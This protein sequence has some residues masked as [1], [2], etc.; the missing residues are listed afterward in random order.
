MFF[1]KKTTPVLELFI[2][3]LFM[4]GCKAGIQTDDLVS[5]F[6]GIQTGEALSPTTIRLSWEKRDGMEYTIYESSSS[7]PLDKTIF[8]S[9][10]VENLTPNTE[11][12]FKVVGT[13]GGEQFGTNRELRV[14]T[15]SRFSGVADL[16]A[17]TETSLEATWNYDQNPMAYQV[18]VG[19]D[20]PP[21][22][23]STN[24]WTA[25]TAT[26]QARTYTISNILPSK[27]YYVRVHAQYTSEEIEQAPR[28]AS[29]L[30]G[31]S[32]KSPNLFLAPISIG[33]LPFIEVDPVPDDTHVRSGFRSQAFWN[34]NAVSD[35]LSG[36]GILIF[37]SNAGLPIGLVEN[38][39]IRVEYGSG[40]SKEVKTIS[41]LKT[42]IKGISPHLEKP[43]V[44]SL[45]QG[46]AYFGKALAR[47]DFNCD[48]VDDL[49]V[50]A[51]E[52]ALGQ[53]GVTQTASGAVFVYYSRPTGSGDAY[54][55]NLS[56]S[57]VPNPARPGID[58]Q[59]IVMSDFQ[60]GMR[61][62]WSLSSGNLNGDK[63]GIFAC[64]DLA[65]GA[66]GYINSRGRLG[67]AFVFFGSPQ[68]LRSS[69]RISDMRVNSE[70]CDGRIESAQCVG[71]LISPDDKHVPTSAITNNLPYNPGLGLGSWRFGHSVKFIGDFDANGYDDLAIGAPNRPWAG[72]VTGYGPS[73]QSTMN[74]VGMVQLYPG[75]AFGL[76]YFEIDN[77]QH[78]AAT[79]FPP[80]PEQNSYFGA[81][82]G[83]GADAD[84]RFKVR[85]PSGELVGGPDL[86]IGAPGFHY[87]NYSQN[88]LAVN[89]GVGTT[90]TS[91]VIV[92]PAD[93]W[94]PSG[95]ALTSTT[96]YYGFPQN[97]STEVG[98][99]FLYF[100]YSKP[101]LQGTSDFD[102]PTDRSNW[103]SCGRR[104]MI[105]DQHYS[106]MA[107]QTSF[108]MLIPRSP[109][110][111]HFGSSVAILGDK[112]RY[113][114]NSNDLLTTR[115]SGATDAVPNEYYSDP[116][117]DG[118]AEVLVGAG[119]SS[120][121]GTQSKSGA[122]WQ[123]FGNS[124]RLFGA[125]DFYNLIGSTDH[126]RNDPNCSAFNGSSDR[127]NCAPT[128]LYSNSLAANARLGG[129][130]LSSS[131]TVNN[132]TE[133]YLY[134]Q[135]A[136]IDSGDVSGDGLKDLVVGVGSESTNG[137][138][139]GGILVFS[140]SQG[141]GLTPTFKKLFATETDAGDTLGY[142]VAV[143]NF[144][145]DRLLYQPN[146]PIAATKR[147]LADV[148]GGA[149]N[150][151]SGA[152][153]IG[154]VFGF[155]SSGSALPSI[156]SSS[157][158]GRGSPMVIRESHASFTNYGAGDI[159]L[160]G[161]INK[162]GFDD[163]V[164]K[165]TEYTS[166][167]S[168]KTDA[169][170][171]YGSSIGLVTKDFCLAN[172]SR[173]FSGSSSDSLC[174]PS[175]NPAF[176]ITKN[177]IALPQR[178]PRPPNLPNNW[179]VKA[180]RVG[181]VN[182]DGYDDVMFVSDTSSMA[183]G[184]NGLATLFFGARGGILNLVTPRFNPS[185]GDPQIVSTQ[186]SFNPPDNNY[187]DGS[188]RDSFFHRSTVDYG[189]FNN[190]GFADVIIGVPAVKSPPMNNTSTSQTLV[191]A[192]DN[193]IAA[194]AGWNCA[195]LTDYSCKEG[196]SADS[197]GMVY[198]I[199][200]SNRGYQTPAVQG[201]SSSD[202]TSLSS[203][204]LI[205][206]L[207][208]E[209]AGTKPCV[210]GVCKVSY[211]RNPVWENI[212]RGYERL[213]H[214]FGATVNVMKVNNDDENDDVLISAPY[215]TDIGCYT[216]SNPPLNYGRIYILY[217]SDDG[218]LA[219]VKDDYYNWRR[220]GVECPVAANNDPALGDPALGMIPSSKLRALAVKPINTGLGSNGIRR[221]YGRYAATIGDVNGDG[222]EDFAVSLPDETI[223]IPGGT[224]KPGTSII[225]YGPLC[226][227]DN[228]A[229][230]TD[231]FQSDGSIYNINVQ[232]Y[233]AGA[234]PVGVP[235]TRTYA[236]APIYSQV[237]CTRSSTLG[238]K[239]L[240]LKFSPLGAATNSQ[241]GTAIS[242]ARKG[243]GDFN[244]DGFDDFLIGSMTIND[245]VRN[246]NSLGKGI[247]F[248]GHENGLTVGEYPTLSLSKGSDSTTYRPIFI[249]PPFG[250]SGST[251]FRG[252]LS[253]GD[254]NNDGTVDYMVP[255]R[256]Y[257]G[258]GNT[259]GI[260]IG[261][262]FIFY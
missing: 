132:V 258:T 97:G 37:S 207:G 23:E 185:V 30:S 22:A 1:T 184:Y 59:I 117:G 76:G 142:A 95:G 252:N 205:D 115:P 35:P 203:P 194:G 40:S 82:I 236:S 158:D 52:I 119:E 58:P 72:E 245:D 217:G 41:G 134:A 51:P 17:L 235:A 206:M 133:F 156:M 83:G 231:W 161:D 10:I 21:T 39:S 223:N 239:P 221:N 240:P 137:S 191:R 171:F 249:T 146:P 152:P 241:Y 200:G 212:D 250:D 43:Q 77:Q 140:S 86:I 89:H 246:I 15:W 20:S 4:M 224:A 145:N 196:R 244:G 180:V 197:H 131:T 174:Y 259:R 56:P 111:R 170:I 99:A 61:F 44:D 100:G 57:P 106:C 125:A 13:K 129:M 93:G 159:T 243:D 177:D 260:R 80:V 50:G 96:N 198:V 85:L 147:P 234:A 110:A 169:V 232:T 2:A 242:R 160:I 118:F 126:R 54:E 261:T 46:A 211:L 68:G 155:M 173:I 3:C 112:S 215:Y 12:V 114:E 192:G 162:D 216:K 166:S 189:D 188:D 47:G 149:P 186:I 193:G 256:A 144:N 90:P 16:N 128:V 24:N 113:R 199:Y 238:Y 65:V 33:S 209:T 204:G 222:F 136:Q 108:K 168:A 181:D 214:M 182:G 19:I 73:G 84:G 254:V 153:S 53:Y 6:S 98:A 101:S 28:V 25:P 70:S 229:S 29:L 253:T 187:E 78:R 167:G 8:D 148:F 34:G 157:N 91:A 94:L 92:P 45:P 150:D 104:G 202:W 183:P 175:E 178:I 172:K 75:S 7:T 123:F 201:L 208:T 213:S 130:S 74:S 31:T 87:S 154:S 42:Y 138:K 102:N 226:P 220:T 109:N 195:S 60:E 64:E 257:N 247:V 121:S 179:F 165:I 163:A 27:T 48:G 227:M 116:N 120:E 5:R 237:G 124:Q 107:N 71:V 103:W 69:T 9:Y 219:G 49:A 67:G 11:Y 151:S 255:S 225:Y 218:L 141:R 18:F 143:G 164:G 36:K 63:N 251:F 262:F 55:L 81:T 228:E 230:V 248:F 127:V 38:I 122:L 176:G 233:V 62:G 210:N 135:G 32:F 105:Q 14:R 88:P 66:P 190:D 79:I 26:T 139:S